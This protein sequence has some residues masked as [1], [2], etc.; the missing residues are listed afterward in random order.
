MIQNY[1]Y[2][3][4]TSSVSITDIFTCISAVA[5]MLTVFVA[6]WVFYSQNRP[7]IDCFVETISYDE[8]LKNITDKTEKDNIKR[9]KE[10]YDL[11]IKNTGNW[12][13]RNIELQI[14][15]IGDSDLNSSKM[16]EINKGRYP[17]SLGKDKEIRI[18]LKVDKELKSDY[19]VDVGI[20][21]NTIYKNKFNVNVKDYTLTEP[22]ELSKAFGLNY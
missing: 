17:K 4:P 8:A 21:Y 10:F 7:R 1:Y 20:K 18:R 16:D 22:D 14:S 3:M 12:S 11:V 13:A 5:T 2:Q 6:I 15:K 9:T 19:S